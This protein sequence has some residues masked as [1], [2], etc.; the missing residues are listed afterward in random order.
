MNLTDDDPHELAK[1]SNIPVGLKNLGAT[2]YAN[3]FLQVWFQDL[4]FRSAVFRCQPSESSSS[5][6]FEESPVFQ[7]QA[8]F[9][10]L[11]ESNQYVYNPIKLVESLQLQ[12]S[13]QQDAQE[14][15]IFAC[16]CITR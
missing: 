12:T 6:K 9:A 13:I 10:A 3:A 7:L 2:C 5:G 1:K 11:Q 15:V 16:L 8:T 4:A 14:S